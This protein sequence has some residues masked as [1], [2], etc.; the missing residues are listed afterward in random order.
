MK[1]LLLCLMLLTSGQY[2]TSGYNSGPAGNNISV[3]QSCVLNQTSNTTTM[4]ITCGS[5]FTAGNTL[6][7]GSS[8]TANGGTWTG[9]AESGADTLTC[10]TLNAGTDFYCYGVS[11]AGGGTTIVITNTNSTFC[12]CVAY[13]LH[14][15]A[16]T[17]P[18]DNT[19][20]TLTQGSAATWTG[21]T[22]TL[23]A[24][25]IFFLFGGSGSTNTTYTAAGGASLPATAKASGGNQSGFGEFQ[26]FA[27]GGSQT[28]SVS[29]SPSTAGR[30][31][32]VAVKVHP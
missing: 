16:T 1:T 22:V 12:T 32:N 9:A 28:L 31:F 25:D 8:N 14:N 5:A 20:A 30:T 21:A 15:T 27:A 24:K 29:L 23:A 2:V 7:V 18:I 4:T 3:V 19:P 6:V 26:I 11:I 17:S 10:A 13:E